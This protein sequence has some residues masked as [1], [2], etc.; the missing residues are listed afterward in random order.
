MVRRAEFQVG[1]G[2]GI[3][4]PVSGEETAVVGCWLDTLVPLRTNELVKRR[5]VTMFPPYLIA[6][7]FVA[8]CSKPGD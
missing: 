4:P 2:D 5:E 1:V 3:R 8:R 7:D 6:R